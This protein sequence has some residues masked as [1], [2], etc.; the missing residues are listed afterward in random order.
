MYEGYAYHAN[1]AP[2]YMPIQKLL[3]SPTHLLMEASESGT[4]PA[5]YI[6]NTLTSWSENHLSNKDSAIPIDQLCELF[7]L[8]AIF[9]NSETGH[10]SPMKNASHRGRLRASASIQEEQNYRRVHHHMTWAHP[11]TLTLSRKDPNW[12]VLFLF[13]FRSIKKQKAQKELWVK[14]YTRKIQNT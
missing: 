11:E 5:A 13:F 12:P 7:Y 9:E 2:H 4:L 10:R 8:S 3:C 14:E 6:F 1:Y